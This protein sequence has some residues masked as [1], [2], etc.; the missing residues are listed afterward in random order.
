M[1]FQTNLS[2]NLALVTVIFF[3]SFVCVCYSD[4]YI[5]LFICYIFC[6]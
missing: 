6:N 5:Y 3:L 1:K 4:L 2:G